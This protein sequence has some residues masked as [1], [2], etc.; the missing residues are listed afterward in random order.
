MCAF[1]C[2]QAHHTT[3]LSHPST[4]NQNHTTTIPNTSSHNTTFTPKHIKPKSY[5]HY[6]Q[7]LFTDGLYPLKIKAPKIQPT[8]TKKKYKNSEYLKL[9]GKKESKNLSSKA[10]PS[11]RVKYCW[12]EGREKRESLGKGNCDG[13]EH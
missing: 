6:T 9:A 5:Y 4:S 2:H 8:T 12:L 3:L 13:R 11:P 1:K 7:H 10:R